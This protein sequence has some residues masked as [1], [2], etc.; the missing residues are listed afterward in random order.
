MY[1]MYKNKKCETFQSIIIKFSCKTSLMRTYVY[2]TELIYLPK[3]DHYISFVNI[4]VPFCI[5]KVKRK[6]KN[7]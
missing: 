7:W 3:N 4:F 1:T 5:Y 6:D 2:F